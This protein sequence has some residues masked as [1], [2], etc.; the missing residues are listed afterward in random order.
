MEASTLPIF[1]LGVLFVRLF[2]SLDAIA[3]GDQSVA[4]AWIKN[5][6]LALDGRPLEKIATIA[7]LIDV[8]AYLDGRR[9]L[10]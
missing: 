8:I 2:R 3:G 5:P 10:V 7:G 6:N 4:R 1:E 9:A